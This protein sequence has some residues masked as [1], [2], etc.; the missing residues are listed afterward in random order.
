M[1]GICEPP[2][3]SGGMA[4]IGAMNIDCVIHKISRGKLAEIAGGVGGSTLS[5]FTESEISD[6]EARDLLSTVSTL[7]HRI[8]LGGSAFNAARAASL[9]SSHQRLGFVGI[10]GQFRGKYPHGDF[11]RARGIET[12]FVEKSQTAAATSLA[13]VYGGDR[14]LVTSRGA[15]IEIGEFLKRNEQK[16]VSYLSSFD[17]IHVTSLFGD[18]NTRSLVQILQNVVRERPGMQISVDPGTI[19]S[20]SRSGAVLQV[21]GL[22]NLIIA[23]EEELY[24]I[25]GKLASET[26][27]DC[28][29]LIVIVIHQ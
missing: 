13:F 1:R 6:C 19:W 16:L 22:A 21:F 18:E 17:A 7:K 12:H 26:D 8:Q 10:A 28:T 4:F 23:G 3:K 2:L 24:E 14:T 9:V 27:E 5:S 15:G 11:F 25:G 29:L 20:K